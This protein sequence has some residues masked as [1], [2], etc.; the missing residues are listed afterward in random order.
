MSRDREPDDLDSREILAASD[1]VPAADAGWLLDRPAD[2]P[3]PPP[4]PGPEAG[5]GAGG[6]GEGTYEVVG[7]GAEADRGDPIPPVVRREPPPDRARSASEDVQPV[8]SA[9]ASPVD[10]LWSRFGEWGTDLL[11]AAGTLVGGL[12]LVALAVRFVGFGAALLALIASAVAVGAA[13]YPV[14]ITLEPPVRLTPEQAVAQYFGA[15]SHARPHFRRMWLLLSDEGKAAPEFGSFDRFRAY[16]VDRLDRLRAEAPDDPLGRW[17][18][19]LHLRPTAFEAPRSQGLTVVRARFTL[20]VAPGPDDRAEPI[21]SFTRALRLSRG[22]D[23]MWY[24]DDGRLD[25]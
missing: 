23:R 12:L 2:R 16:W 18:N 7:G 8:P 17:I 6:E 21:A 9:E 22:G 19:R 4:E 3:A 1:P 15:A 13:L 5:P 10:P 11:R 24:L 25:P 14:L 20:E